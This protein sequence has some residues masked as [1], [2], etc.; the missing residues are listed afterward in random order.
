[1]TLLHR[2]RKRVL[3]TLRDRKSIM[4][5][6]YGLHRTGAAYA[7]WD[8]VQGISTHG[9]KG[10]LAMAVTTMPKKSSLYILFQNWAN[11][12]QAQ[13][14]LPHYRETRLIPPVSR[15]ICAQC[16]SKGR[17]LRKTRVKNLPWDEFRCTD[18]GCGYQG[19]SHVNNARVA[20]LRLKDQIKSAPLPLST[21]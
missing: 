8:A 12:L 13:G 20:A 7:A 19:I 16:V 10:T 5:Y 1:M 21:G 17:G 4:L 18:P 14:F 9:T 15:E 3:Q 11:D 2:R 6:L